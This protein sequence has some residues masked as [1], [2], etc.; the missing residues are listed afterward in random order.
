[1]KAGSRSLAATSFLHF[2]THFALLTH[3]AFVLV[4]PDRLGVTAAAVGRAGVLGYLLF[5]VLAL[6]AGV[7]VDLWGSRRVLFLTGVGIA[8][9]A[10]GLA[11]AS[12]LPEVAISFAVLGAGAGLYHPSG[13]ALLARRVPAHRRP[14]AM[15]LHGVAGNLG[16]GTAPFV[17]F[18]GLAAWGQSPFFI[19]LGVVALLAGLV[20][21]SLPPDPLPRRGRRKRDMLAA[22]WRETRPG[23]SL[24]LVWQAVVGTFYRL[25]TT[26]LPAVLALALA[27]VGMGRGE[28]LVM[29]LDGDKYFGSL[30]ASLV[31][32]AGVAFQV[33]AGRWARPGRLG[34]QLS[35]LFFGLAALAVLAFLP[36]LAGLVALGLLGAA[37]FG[38]QPL[39]N[40][41]LPTFV[42]SDHQGIG[43]GIQFLASF[44]AGAV[45]ALLGAF[46]LGP[47]LTGRG[48]WLAG[49][50]VAA[51]VAALLM[52][53]LSRHEP[54]EA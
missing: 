47:D 17:G 11:R 28:G 14:R 54:K 18:V 34:R 37:I 45:G 31:L 16:I 26:Y 50:A 39:S 15:A 41:L 40:S 23:Y 42:G 12:T 5:G 33:A 43:Y 38:H 2:L 22:F 21:L 48:P 13:L 52:A 30:L 44:G 4:L 6:A 7:L 46:L 32:G 9:G 8:L 3:A 27:G 51:M 29:G 1:M 35:A 20:A 19:T 53:R 25:L 24:L 36:G 49:L 10:F